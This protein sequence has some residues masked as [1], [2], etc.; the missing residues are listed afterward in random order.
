MSGFAACIHFD[1]SRPDPA[2]AGRM[3]ARMAYRGP[4]GM[5]HWSEGPASLGH[6]LMQATSAQTSPQP[7]SHGESGVTLAMDG[8]LANWEELTAECEAR[9][10][11][12]HHGDDAELV[13][14]AYLLWGEQCSE[15]LEG[16]FSA[17]LWDARQQ[18]ALCL[19]DHHGLRPFYY[20]WDGQKLIAASEI[21][22]V[23]AALGSTPPLNL[24]YLAEQAAALSFT[25]DETVWCGI[26]RLLPAHSLSV[27]ASGF[28]LREYWTLP[29]T[30]ETPYR[31]DSEYCEAYRAMFAECV[32]RS[33]RSH[34][35]LACEVS[36]G[37][38]SSAVYAM[39]QQLH[40]Q[41]ALPA[42]AI[43]GYTL[44][45]PAGSEADELHY[46]RAVAQHW[47]SQLCE[48]PLFTPPLDW[49]A[50]QA[51]ED[52][53]MPPLPN[54][55]MSWNLDLAAAKDGARVTLTGV[56]GDQWLDGSHFAYRELLL[57]G[58]WARL[59]TQYREEAAIAGHGEASAHLLRYGVV[60]FLP[61]RVRRV[62][63][64]LLGGASAE[65]DF[66][67]PWL[68]QSLT[69]ELAQR[70][71]AYEEQF[72]AEHRSAYK[73][74]KLKFPRWTVILD[75]A[76][77]QRARAGLEMRSP[78]M[79]KKFI[80]FSATTPEHMRLRGA[81]G[82]YI[83]R[84]ALRALLPSAVNQRS[85]KAEFS[86]VYHCHDEHM[87][88]CLNRLETGEDRLFDRGQLAALAA[89]YL[90]TNIDERYTGEIW[91]T[92]VALILM[93]LEQTRRQGDSES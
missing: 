83:H 29:T 90:A 51:A 6:C 80:E 47:N 86:T 68:Q 55:A 24:G 60:S 66:S 2:I 88:T 20:H 57:T 32:R 92:Y 48:R 35:P 31:D 81:T 18:R 11:R 3:T 27:S 69:R 19:R 59:V 67:A 16:E 53:D 74:R 39:A 75:S 33:A 23:I 49:F 44:S 58:N 42:S 65:D 22:P 45:G 64:T 89:Q 54:A 17:I 28:R 34:K 87:V 93:R 21:T 79:A 8:Y 73:L 30:V 91:G 15:R 72:P 25:S 1:G 40:S 56:G 43:R 10:I 84:E 14:H 50:H 38:D 46:A 76:N 36:G 61:T 7:L 52:C 78:M 62:I 13:L 77:R 41:S 5:R 26:K 85:S 63:R 70:Q 82:K 12:L 9:S 4:D 71:A 37:L